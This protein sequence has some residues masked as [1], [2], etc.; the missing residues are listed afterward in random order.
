MCSGFFIST[1]LS[2]PGA[3]PLLPSAANGYV[4]QIDTRQDVVL[5][6]IVFPLLTNAV[7]VSAY[8]RMGTLRDTGFL[9]SQEGW[10]IATAGRCV[11]SDPMLALRAADSP[12]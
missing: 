4:L 7:F 1:A 3:P 12:L 10:T 8:F 5:T 6:S 11:S 9:Q 2:G